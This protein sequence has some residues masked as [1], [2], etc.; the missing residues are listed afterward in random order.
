VL[1]EFKK[2][3][4]DIQR[5]KKIIN[6][7]NHRHGQW[8]SLTYKKL[9]NPHY[10]LDILRDYNALG[11]LIP[12][13]VLKEALSQ[14]IPIDSSAPFQS[15]DQLE[16]IINH[17]ISSSKSFKYW[18]LHQIFVPEDQ[19]E[20]FTVSIQGSDVLLNLAQKVDPDDHLGVISIGGQPI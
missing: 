11:L 16:K 12:N 2:T 8:C 15:V 14:G 7:F 4:D 13:K 20:L 1:L 17:K 18:V 9:P 10:S 5:Q 19:H 6:A 3:I